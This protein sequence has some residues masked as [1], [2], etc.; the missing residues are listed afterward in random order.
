MQLT[1][2]L[3]IMIRGM[4]GCFGRAYDNLCPQCPQ[5]IL[6]FLADLLGHGEDHLVA[7]RGRKHC[8]GCAGIA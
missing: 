4:R 1:R 3:D 6:F 2:P 5:T 7:P 8:D